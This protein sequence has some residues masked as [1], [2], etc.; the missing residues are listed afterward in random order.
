MKTYGAYYSPPQ[1]ILHVYFD[2]LGCLTAVRHEMAHAL[3]RE[4]VDP[5]P[6]QW[7]DEGVGV[8]CQFAQPTED[9]SFEFGRFPRHAFGVEFVNQV[10]GGTRERIAEIHTA[11]HVTMNSHYYSKFRSLVDFFMTAGNNRYRMTF[12]D[13]MFRHQGAIDR[14]LTL[15][16]IDAEWTDYV[17][18]LSIDTRWHWR[19]NPAARIKLVEKVLAAG[20]SAAAFPAADPQLN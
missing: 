19:P 8:M 10:K 18:T 4:Y 3:N 6:P 7:F 13:A 5:N 12:I 20:T 17:Q 2:R 11:G 14:L 16:N 9:G 15:P 1:Q